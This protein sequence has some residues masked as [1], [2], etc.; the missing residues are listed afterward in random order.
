MPPVAKTL[1]PA[2]WAQIMVAATVVAPVRP[3]AMQTARSARLSFMASAGGV[4]ARARSASGVRPIWI[5]PPMTA[6]VAGTAPPSRMVASTFSAISR[7][8][9]QGMPWVMIVDSSATTGRPRSSASRTSG[10]KVRGAVWVTGRP[11][12]RHARPRP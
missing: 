3:F 8:W 11:F 5:W 2:S 9:G 12:R 6:M 1:M 4:W 10:A 7:F